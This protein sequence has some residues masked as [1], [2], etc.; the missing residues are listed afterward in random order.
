VDFL[1]GV[2]NSLDVNWNDPLF[3]RESIPINDRNVMLQNEFSQ[4]QLQNLEQ[5]ERSCAL[6]LMSNYFDIFL[7]YLFLVLFS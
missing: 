6:T 7:Y 4:Q 3:P 2:G 5:A 1:I